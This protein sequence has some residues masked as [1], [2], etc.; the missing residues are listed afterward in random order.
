MRIDFS[1]QRD[2]LLQ[3]ISNM[4]TDALTDLI[5]GSVRLINSSCIWRNLEILP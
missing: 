2:G 3:E 4:E 5:L 1:V